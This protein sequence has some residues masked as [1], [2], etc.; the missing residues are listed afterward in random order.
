MD[1]PPGPATPSRGHG[2]MSR[3]HLAMPLAGVLPVPASPG[4]LALPRTA[5]RERS[6]PAVPAGL[7][8]GHCSHPCRGR[9]TGPPHRRRRTAEKR[10]PRAGG[11]PAGAPVRTAGSRTLALE[12]DFHLAPGSATPGGARP[13]CSRCRTC[14]SSRHP[15]R[16]PGTGV[17]PIPPAPPRSARPD[18]PAPG[19]RAWQGGNPRPEG[20]ARCETLRRCPASCPDTGLT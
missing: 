2:H 9:G 16:V 13:G 11:T 10:T 14:R 19:C 8:P 7:V 1:D 6:L 3:I 18:R 15:A 20:Q 5:G 12:M 17:K 4:S